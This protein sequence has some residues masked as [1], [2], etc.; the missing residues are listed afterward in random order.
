MLVRFDG[1]ALFDAS[2]NFNALDQTRRFH[3][4]FDECSSG[5]RSAPVG[6]VELKWIET[7]H[8]NKCTGTCDPTLLS[9]IPA[10]SWHLHWYFEKCVST[11]VGNET[12]AIV[13]LSYLSSKTWV[14]PEEFL[15]YL[16]WKRIVRD[17]HLNSGWSTGTYPGKYYQ[18]IEW[19]VSMF[20]LLLEWSHMARCGIE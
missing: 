11:H 8:I 12:E 19:Y 18:F 2:I 10:L 15:M 1:S 20:T 16:I 14:G 9:L 5:A 6:R 3:I 13:I 7:Q 17:L 4:Q